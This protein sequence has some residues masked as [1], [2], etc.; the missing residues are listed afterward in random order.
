MRRG[1]NTNELFS[2]WKYAVYPKLSCC[3][4]SVLTK[5]KMVKAIKLYKPKRTARGHIRFALNTH[6]NQLFVS[7]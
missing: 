6:V 4:V 5:I 1:E 2:E 3:Y 7:L